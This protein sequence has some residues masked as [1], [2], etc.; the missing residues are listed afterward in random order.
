M[1]ASELPLDPGRRE[2]AVVV[3]GGNDWEGQVQSECYMVI[4]LFLALEWL[5]SLFCAREFLGKK[6]GLLWEYLV[7]FSSA[8]LYSFSPI[9]CKKK[10]FPH[11]QRKQFST[12]WSFS[13]PFPLA[14]A[15][16]ASAVSTSLPGTW[17]VLLSDGN[18]YSGSMT[19]SGI[20]RWRKAAQ[21]KVPGGHRRK[22]ACAVGLPGGILF[23]GGYQ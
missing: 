5:E 2:K 21:S 14:T 22:H 1:T 9:N 7:V 11:F 13:A 16:A 3:C 10:S 12:R 15:S 23:T 4:V 8:F 18:V 20:D 19:A 6:S 17:F